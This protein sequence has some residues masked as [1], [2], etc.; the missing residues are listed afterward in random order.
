MRRNHHKTGLAPRIEKFAVNI[1]KTAAGELILLP[2][3]IAT[4]PETISF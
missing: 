3:K 4:H 2:R 1:E